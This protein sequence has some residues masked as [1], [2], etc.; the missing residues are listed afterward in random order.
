LSKIDFENEVKMAQNG[1]ISPPS[2][3][4][5][6]PDFSESSSDLIGG[7]PNPNSNL[8]NFSQDFQ[9]N[10]K[11]TEQKARFDQ[12]DKK[13]TKIDLVK[14][15]KP[16]SLIRAEFTPTSLK[17]GYSVNKLV[18]ANLNEVL[19]SF[20]DYNLNN[21]SSMRPIFVESSKT[22]YF[23]YRWGKIAVLNMETGDLKWDTFDFEIAQMSLFGGKYYLNE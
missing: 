17:D 5:K 18:D 7:N 13:I 1:Q 8:R 16:W 6:I 9:T 20:N 19:P 4:P 23:P 10:F 2:N 22:L 21:S 3:L 12:I 15:P 14:N 11:E